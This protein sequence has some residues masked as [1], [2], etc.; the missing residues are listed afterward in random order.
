MS[1]KKALLVV[2]FGTSYKESLLRSIEACEKRLS[3][4]FSSYE[5]RRAFTSHKII[6]KLNREYNIS[7]ETPTMALERLYLE[8]FSDVLVQ[9][10][11]IIPGFE[12]NDKI[13]K[14]S[15]PFMNK[16]NSL[17]VGQ[18]LLCTYDDYEDLLDSLNRL[19]S[20]LKTSEFVLFMGHGT[21]HPANS[22]YSCLQKIIDDRSLPIQIGCVEA[23]PEIE[24]VIKR[25]KDKNIKKIHL[26]P[27]ML[28]AGD[29]AINDMAG[30]DNSWR[31]ILETLGY[32]V[33]CHLEGLGESS[34]IQD[35]FVK[36]AK[37][38]L[39]KSATVL[40]H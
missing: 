33:E 7:I 36:K 12:Y 26:Y 19:I 39:L 16:F 25:L 24:T 32:E 13:L 3:T 31:S 17:V 9:P 2:S 20:P 40:Q 1:I 18:P 8:G 15:E 29:H 6:E 27:L 30:D 11:H 35:M 38:S 14:P 34:N 21:N 28:V 37:T 22:S 10:L 23:Y 5:V 4:E